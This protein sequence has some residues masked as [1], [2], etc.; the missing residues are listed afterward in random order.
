M[1]VHLENAGSSD[2]GCRSCWRWFS[3]IM[4]KVTVDG[5]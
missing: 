1:K 4:E 3:H 2:V 5:G